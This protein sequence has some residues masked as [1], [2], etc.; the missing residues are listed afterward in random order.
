MKTWLALVVS[1]GVVCCAK[2]ETIITPT[3]A[4][5]LLTPAEI[6][7]DPL[8]VL[9]SGFIAL[10][11]AEVPEVAKSSL[12]PTLIALANKMAPLPPS[13]G[14]VPERDL[15]RVVVGLYSLQ[16][17]DAAGIATG[18][19]NPDA[20]SNAAAATT[21]TPSG[22]LVMS[23]YAGHLL[24]TV[25]NVG[26][27]VLSSRT[28]LFGNE[29]GIRRSLDRIHDG[30]AVHELP[31]WTNVVLDVTRAPLAFGANLKSSAVPEGLTQR[32]PFL[33]GL[34]AARGLGNFAPPGVNWA[35]SLGYDTPERAQQA[36][37]QLLASR[38][39]LTSYGWIMGVL[40]VTQ[41][42][43]KL[44]AQATDREVSF[45]VALNGPALAK[46][47]GIVTPAL[48]SGAALGAGV[49]KP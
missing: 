32:L 3:V 12:G 17:V 23:P 44:E 31:E 34:N 8:A 38:D 49:G 26:F 21:N 18:R 27:C 16:G 6:D 10:M 46:I 39:L 2:T 5:H 28:L 40:G 35:G 37:G 13:S 25:H 19:F 45:V 41:P 48:V 1:F 15:D 30:R 29:T 11:R 42:I 4:S 22:P 33:A 9:P 43:E 7:A 47:L 24:Y 36:A 14:F 20:I